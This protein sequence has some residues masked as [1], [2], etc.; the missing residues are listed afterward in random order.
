MEIQTTST[1]KQFLQAEKLNTKNNK[2]YYQRYDVK[3]LISFH[4]QAMIKQQIYDNMLARRSGMDYSPGIQSETSIINM[5][6]A[7]ELTM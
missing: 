2:S 3:Q 6:E 4:K 5:K 1:F 7:Q